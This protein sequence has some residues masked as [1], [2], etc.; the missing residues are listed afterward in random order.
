MPPSKAELMAHLVK[1]LDKEKVKF[2]PK[3]VAFIVASYYPDLRKMINFAQQ[4]SLTGELIISKANAADQD[5]REKPA[6]THAKPL[7][8]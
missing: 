8:D 7:T 2:T 6:R 4:S 5:Y 3:D 1:I